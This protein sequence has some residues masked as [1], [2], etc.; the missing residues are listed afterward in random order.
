MTETDTRTK[1]TAPGNIEYA[2]RYERKFFIAPKN[3]GLAYATLREVCRLDLEY[4]E[5]EVNSLYFDTP[6]LE[7]Y[8]HSES[9]DFKKQKVRI[10]WY[11]RPGSNQKSVPVF[12][13]L[14]SREGFASSKKRR[15][16]LVPA[17]HL[18]LANLH[19]GIVDNKVL[20]DTLAEFG[21]FPSRPLKPVIL[22]CY[23]R[24]RFSEILTGIRVS[25]DYN[26]VSTIVASNLGY[27][28]RNLPLE[29]GV[30]EVKGPTLE[31]PVMLRH[32]KVLDLDW[33]RF[34]KYGQCIEAHLS[35]PGSI[36]RSWPSGR[37]P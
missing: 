10:R 27:G 13:E 19:E 12:L 5:C 35:Q 32:L 25:F 26:I 24:Y 31:L 30:I 16:L 9:G 18:E 20:V 11:D 14:K 8:E 4:P 2:P 37:A 6:D 1:Q 34:S 33:S 7:Q 15:R 21:L 17:R 23:R 36:A 3:I 29:G 22:I 28:E